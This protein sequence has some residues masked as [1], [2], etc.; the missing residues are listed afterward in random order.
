MT[1]TL[2]T[3]R[4]ELMRPLVPNSLGAEVG[5]H[6]GHFSHELV[7]LGP[8]RVYL[9]DCW[10]HQPVGIY[11]D[12]CN[13]HQDQQDQI[14]KSCMDLHAGDIASG[15]VVVQRQFSLDAARGWAGPKLDWVYLDA[16]HS[17]E[18]VYQDLWAWA[19]LLKPDGQQM[20][21]RDRSWSRKVRKT[22][23]NPTRQWWLSP[24]LTRTSYGLDLNWARSGTGPSG[25]SMG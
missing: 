18:A 11:V 16:N 5:V 19:A 3:T 25:A 12:P 13:S 2:V 7:K 1:P 9:V 17:F 21:I 20:C 22:L 6:Y 24:Q 14:Y 15:Q 4:L 23:F 10:K 8:R